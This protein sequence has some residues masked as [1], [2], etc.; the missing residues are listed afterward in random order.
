MEP[1]VLTEKLKVDEALGVAIEDELPRIPALGK[2]QHTRGCLAAMRPPAESSRIEC[3][4]SAQ[5]DEFPA[6][7][8]VETHGP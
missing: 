4:I 8:R 1:A 3:G 6:Q 7:V 5:W 2:T